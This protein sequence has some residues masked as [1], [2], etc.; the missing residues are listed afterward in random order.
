MPHYGQA[1]RLDLRCRLMSSNGV[2]LTA[3]E[4]AR[5]AYE[6]MMARQREVAEARRT[7]ERSRTIRVAV[8]A[9][10]TLAILIGTAIYN[11]WM[12]TSLRSSVR[13]FRDDGKFVETRTGQIRSFIKGN[14]CQELQFNNDRGVYVGGNY[15]PC[16]IESKREALPPPP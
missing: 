12:P 3:I 8:A 4:R 9:V 16:Q 15:V 5:I 13:S 10:G 14:T 6:L 2:R 11:G 1:L 7:R